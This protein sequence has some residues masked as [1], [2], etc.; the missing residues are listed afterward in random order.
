[1]IPLPKQIRES[2]KCFWMTSRIHYQRNAD[3]PEKLFR[4]LVA[5][6]DA[7]Y[8]NL[9]SE[10]FLDDDNTMSVRFKLAPFTKKVPPDYYFLKV[11]TLAIQIQAETARGINRL[12]KF[13][14]LRDIQFI[15][16]DAFSG[17]C[18]P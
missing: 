16:G 12:N 14:D 4:F 9:I 5:D 2:K 11:D 15:Q 17:M 6:L 8:H 3:L 18:V 7:Y 10:G 13:F 1:M